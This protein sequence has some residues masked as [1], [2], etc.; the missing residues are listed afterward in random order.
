MLGTDTDNTPFTVY[1]YYTVTDPINVKTMEEEEV[2]IFEVSEVI[3]GKL[4]IM[5]NLPWLITAALDFITNPRPPSF[6]TANY[7]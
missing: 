3:A 1:C 5:K 4:P 7:E 2:G 6:I